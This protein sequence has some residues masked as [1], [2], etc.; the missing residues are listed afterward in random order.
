MK[1]K[2]YIFIGDSLTFGYGVSKNLNWVS[3]LSSYLDVNIYN[4]GINGNTSFDILNR[5][6]EDVT[7]LNPNI[8]FIMCGTNDL[9]SNKS[10]KSIIDNIELMIK[11]S[12]NNNIKPVI[13]IPP[14]IIPDLAYRL[15]Y[16]TDTYKYS[17]ES[18]KRLQSS[19]VSLCSEYKINYIDFYTLTDNNVNKNIFLDGIH[20]NSLGNNLLLE[21][22]KKN[23]TI[24]N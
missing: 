7:N 17:Y 10:V 21:Y 15:F 5:F 19:L 14:T 3:M 11:E 4:K 6:T 9:L 1:C 8:V 13:G 16:P 20:L 12:L 22:I 24:F 18:L 2:K 23:C